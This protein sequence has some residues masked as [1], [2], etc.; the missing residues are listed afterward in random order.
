MPQTLDY[1]TP[2]GPKG[3]DGWALASLLL[4]IVSLAALALVFVIVEQ[5]KLP[6][7]MGEAIA[8]YAMVVI[9]CC[10]IPGATCGIVS[11]R[12]HGTS[13]MSIVGLVVG[14]LATYLVVTMF[15][16]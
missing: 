15:S 4:A 5:Q 13:A 7:E 11:M 14:L 12:K 2:S 8:G 10:G 1:E 6:G 9:Y 3:P 16:Q